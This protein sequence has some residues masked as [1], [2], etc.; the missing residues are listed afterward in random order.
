MTRGTRGLVMIAPLAL[1]LAC[2]GAKKGGP[3]PLMPSCA[4]C[5]R[6]R[7]GSPTWEPTDAALFADKGLGDI[8]ASLLGPKH[9]YFLNPGTFGPAV[10]HSPPY[11]QELASLLAMRA[12]APRQALV[13]ADFQPH[14]SLILIV[15]V[16]PTAGAPSGSSFDFAQ[17]PIIPNGSF[18][19][20]ARVRL[21]RDGVPFDDHSVAG[22]PFQA[23]G[24]PIQVQG[25]DHFFPPI[26]ADGASHVFLT[27]TETALSTPAP[28]ASGEPP[29]A[30]Q[31]PPAGTYAL[32]IAIADVGGDGWVV[33][34]PFTVNG[35][36]GDG[37]ADDGASSLC[38]GA[39]PVRDLITDFSDATTATPVRT[40]VAFG[41]PPN[42]VGRAYAY[43]ARNLNAPV[44]SLVS[45][46]SPDG[47][48]PSNALAIAV[49]SGTSSDPV[50]AGAFGFGL[51]F[52]RCIDAAAYRGIRFTID[53]DPGAC[54][55]RFAI[56]FAEDQPVERNPGVAS[57]T[58]APSCRLPSEP[59]LINHRPEFHAFDDDDF[60]NRGSPLG[61]LDRQRI[62]GVEWQMNVPLDG[63]SCTANFTVRDISF[64]SEIRPP[65]CVV[66]APVYSPVIVGDGSFGP[67]FFTP[68]LFTFG[69]P[70]LTP[71]VVV[72]MRSGGATGDLESLQVTVDPGPAVDPANA[73][74][75]FGL[76]LPQS[77]VD[78]ADYN[79]IRFTAA[80]DLGTCRLALAASPTED[81]RVSTGLP[82]RRGSCADPVCRAPRSPPLALGTNVVHFADLRGG[83]PRD[84]IDVA[85]LA[86]LEWVFT[87]PT[88]GV[89]LPC[90]ANLTITDVSFIH[91]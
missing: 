66:L 77:C 55:P 1:A 18:P 9:Q 38:T 42:I 49:H 15:E 11:D 17:G 84:T 29:P 47:G 89:T 88:D 44:V 76:Y 78:V 52:D 61:G 51:A 70:P 21:F 25:Y 57:C 45:T 60:L 79:A 5:D 12:I 53:G 56:N 22:A 81:Q 28:S 85:F 64:Y 83:V 30:I 75:G 36:S 6:T 80:G 2:G 71:P 54:T 14:T 35:G 62:T 74:V 65:P 69:A 63:N 23:E 46:R 24:V 39:L 72:Q 32:N 31:A 86:T 87:A 16:V 43:A 3:P 10:P 27:L 7:S 19:V 26:V 50:N 20:S 40:G 41:T 91:D 37:G 4:G 58:A 59:T 90:K 8:V 34:L 13:S 48:A 33:N 73:A 67:S 82:P 68:E